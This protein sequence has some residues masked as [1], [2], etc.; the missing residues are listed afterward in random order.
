MARR[1]KT[2]TENFSELLEAGD[3]DALKKVY[4]TCE[5]DAYDGTYSKMT[6]LAFNLCPDELA[7]WLVEQGADINKP[8]YYGRTPIMNRAHSQ[9]G[10]IKGLLKLGADITVCNEGGNTALH[11]AAESGHIEN[12]KLLLKFGAE[13]DQKNEGELSAIDHGLSPLEYT[14]QQC[15]PMRIER[16]SEVAILLLGSGAKNTKKAKIYIKKIGERFEFY[17]SEYDESSRDSTSD[18]IDNL[19]A[20]FKVPP[21]LRKV[22]FDNKS[23]IVI[24]EWRWKKQYNELWNMLVPGSGHAVTVQGEVIRISGR[25]SDEIDGNG[26]ANWDGE[27]KE[28]GQ[29]FLKL[30]ATGKPLSSKKLDKA[31]SVLSSMEKLYDESEL[32]SKYAVKWV[33]QNTMPVKM[34]KP[35]YKR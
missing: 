17:R 13:I 3:I 27:Y 1:R 9:V 18:A 11:Y 12:V 22:V 16:V 14:L 4:D 23:K 35:N 6:A 32:L 7:E 31:K 2:L 21:A 28:M 5:L 26:G 20:K 15:V 24:R 34:E 8:D 29:F 25:I 19:Y 33:T 30:I 10:Q